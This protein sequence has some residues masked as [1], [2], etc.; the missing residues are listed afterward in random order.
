MNKFN[1]IVEP[2]IPCLMS[3][4]TIKELSLLE[5][6]TRAHEIKEITDD[7]PL[8]V[9]SLYRLLLAILHR[10][11]GPKNFE[12]WKNL[13]REGFW[14]EEKL[15]AY[16]ESEHC[17][18]RFNLFDAERPFYQY[19]KVTK[20]GGADSDRLPIETLM[21]EKATGANATLFDHSFKGRETNCPPSV[22]ARYLI[23]RQSFSLAGGVSYPFNLSNG[24]LVKG[25]S[26]L[27]IGENLFQTLAL[28]LI[29]YPSERL[30]PFEEDDDG[31]SLDKP[32]WERETL[33]EAAERDKEGTVP[34]GYLDYLTWQSR[35]IKVLLDEE[36]Q[37]VKSCQLQQNFKLKENLNLFDPF[38]VYV[39]GEKGLYALDFNPNKSLW[40]NSHTIFRQNA[41][42]G[43]IA[44][45][46]KHLTNI[47]AAI[48]NGEIE[49][50]RRY[51]LS[52]FGIVNDQ[53]SVE[54][55]ARETLPIP[56]DYFDDDALTGLLERA[57]QFAEEKGGIAGTLRAGIK[58]LAKSLETSAA[59]FP[60]MPIYWSSLEL[61]FQRLLLDL[62]DE[63]DAAMKE[64][65]GFVLRTA[66][67]AFRQTANG[68]SGTAKEQRAI[69]EA[70]AE[71]RKQKNI[72]LSKHKT[73]WGKYLPETKAK[74][75][76]Q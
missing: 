15:K 17:R 16:F 67:D 22:A 49:G 8:V 14:D 33:Q 13:W 9:V 25:F 58:E 66:D 19:P 45:L 61:E 7:S 40:R 57:I 30:M 2:W 5:T 28:N 53:A 47:S 26:V 68:L 76:N 55:W 41:L 50:R 59:N 36:S 23:A 24:L 34:R 52:I 60:A 56:L 38:K 71:F 39:E 21:Q 72:L 35:R 75:G 70:E 48:S 74:G 64:W 12:E 51:A 44:N 18:N 3:D 20:K 42:P 63:K 11:F 43:E 31:V 46:S 32:F 37:T 69:V 65:F 62:P 6:L 1:L 4:D 10:I 29:K 54:M 27:A 73:D